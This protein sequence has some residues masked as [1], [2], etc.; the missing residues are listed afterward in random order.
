[1][2]DGKEKETRRGET[3]KRHSVFGNGSVAIQLATHSGGVVV[4]FLITNRY[5][6]S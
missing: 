5:G 1:M 6:S 4:D 3:E 2:K